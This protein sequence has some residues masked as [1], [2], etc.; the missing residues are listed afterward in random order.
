M[1]SD[2]IADPSGYEGWGWRNEAWSWGNEI[3]PVLEGVGS[4]DRFGEMCL[5]RIQGKWVFE[6]R[7]FQPRRLDI[8]VRVF[9]RSP[10][11]STTR[12]RARPS[13]AAAVGARRG[14]H[15]GAALWPSIVS[16]SRLDRGF[17]IL[18]SQWKTDG[19]D[20]G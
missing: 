15:G 12:T 2:R 20:A 18:S 7:F 16:G 9:P 19:P 17:R 10:T 1:R 3:T 5:R 14:R 6:L 8:D 11:T 4:A 13:G